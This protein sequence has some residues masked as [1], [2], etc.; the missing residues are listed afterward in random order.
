MKRIIALFL[1]MLFLFSV[2]ASAE[3]SDYLKWRKRFINLSADELQDAARALV[4]VLSFDDIV[5]LRSNLDRVL[6]E[7]VFISFASVVS[8]LN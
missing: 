2:T 7:Y 1:A 3:D 4:S 5:T 6:F 8:S